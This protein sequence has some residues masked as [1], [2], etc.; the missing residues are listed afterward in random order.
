[1]SKS[2]P[3]GSD[4]SQPT[5]GFFARRQLVDELGD[6]VFELLFEARI[7][8]GDGFLAVGGIGGREAEIEFLAAGVDGHRRDAEFGG[9]VFFFGERLRV[10]HLERELAVGARH[11]FFE[12]LAHADAVVA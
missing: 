2:P 4:D 10:D 12:Q 9:A 5:T 3:I 7:E 11:Q 8:I 6:V 1:M